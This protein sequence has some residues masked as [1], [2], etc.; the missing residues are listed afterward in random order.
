M[1]GMCND[2][3]GRLILNFVTNKSGTSIKE[4]YKEAYDKKK[5]AFVCTEKK[6]SHDFAASVS[7]RRACSMLIQ[8]RPS[9][10]AFA[11]N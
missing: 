10:L 5:T 2:K 3:A 7:L 8:R 11:A 1:S 9:R 6:K 4:V